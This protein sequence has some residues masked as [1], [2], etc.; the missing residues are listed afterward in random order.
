MERLVD[1]HDALLAAARKIGREDELTGDSDEHESETA[2]DDLEQVEKLDPDGNPL[3]QWWDEAVNH[4]MRIAV[5]DAQT[6]VN[7]L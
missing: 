5:V 7:R 6:W 1:L 4:P 2:V 3:D